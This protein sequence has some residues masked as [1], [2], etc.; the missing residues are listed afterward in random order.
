MDETDTATVEL[1][2]GEA[3]ELINALSAY[4]YS[5]SGRDDDLALNIRELLQREFGFEDRH[6]E[7]DQGL[8]ESF[9]EVFDTSDSHEVQ[10]SRMEAKEVVSA[11]SESQ[12]DADPAEAETI[13]S[14]REEFERTFDLNGRTTT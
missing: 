11:L 4:R 9:A 14:I 5:A 8:V 1:T 6:F 10:F 3:R 2:K 7:N 13:E 12:A